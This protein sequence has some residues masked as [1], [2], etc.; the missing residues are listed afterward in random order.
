M[1]HFGSEENALWRRVIC[2]HY[3]VNRT[4][5]TWEWKSSLDDSVF[6]R[7]VASLFEGSTTVS[8][9]LHSGLEVVVG[10]GGR[11]DF[12]GIPSSDMVQLKTTCPRIISLAIQKKRV[13]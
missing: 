10:N 12:W 7:A 1:W 4:S 11:D 3:G 2:A 9:A 13:I 6:V 8:S 5:L